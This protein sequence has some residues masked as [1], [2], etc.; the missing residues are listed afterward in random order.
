MALTEGPLWVYKDMLWVHDANMKTT[1]FS[2]FFSWLSAAY[3]IPFSHLKLWSRHLLQEAFPDPYT[4]LGA[5]L[6]Q[7]CSSLF[8]T[9][10]TLLAN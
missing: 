9:L 5:V 8:P 7:A 2:S 10:I 4:E 1:N 3:L 6:P